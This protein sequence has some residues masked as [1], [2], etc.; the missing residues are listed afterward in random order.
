ML[1]AQIL[2]IGVNIAFTLFMVVSSFADMCV[3]STFNRLV[4]SRLTLRGSMD[5]TVLCMLSLR[6]KQLTHLIFTVRLTVSSFH[7]VPHLAHTAHAGHAAHPGRPPVAGG[8]H[9]RPGR[10]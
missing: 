6:I 9:V 5:N 2:S 1:L 7:Q 4:T 8:L 3:A 10:L